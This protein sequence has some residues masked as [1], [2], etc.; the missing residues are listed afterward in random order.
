M[1][2]LSRFGRQRVR[3]GCQG[4]SGNEWGFG[5]GIE[6]GFRMQ[7]LD[8]LANEIRSEGQEDLRKENGKKDGE[9]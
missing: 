4:S 9:N 8:L 2:F 6:Y 5:L 1:Q 3:S 7:G